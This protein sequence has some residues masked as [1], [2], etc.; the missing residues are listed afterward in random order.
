MCARIVMGLYTLQRCPSEFLVG[1]LW[2]LCRAS[3]GGMYYIYIYISMPIHTT[4]GGG[5]KCVHSHFPR[6]WACRLTTHLLGGSG[7]RSK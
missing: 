3:I 1:V 2:G 5:V 6:E 7:G 4:C